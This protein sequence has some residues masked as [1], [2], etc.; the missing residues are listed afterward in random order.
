MQTMPNTPAPAGEAIATALPTEKVVE[1]T[2]PVK[3]NFVQLGAFKLKENADLLRDKLQ[4]QKLTQNVDIESWYNDGIY[5]VR[6][7]PY[8]S[9]EDAEGAANQIRQSLG[10]SA[11]VLTQ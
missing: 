2:L 4:Q 10:I 1:K 11:L 5:R 7:G 9:R 3:G 6:L 8:N